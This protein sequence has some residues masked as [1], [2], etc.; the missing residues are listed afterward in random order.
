MEISVGHLLPQPQ[1]PLLEGL[2]TNYQQNNEDN[3]EAEEERYEEE[4]DVLFL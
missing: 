1:R 2:K 4:V 3:I